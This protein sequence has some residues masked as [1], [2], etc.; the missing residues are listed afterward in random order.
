MCLWIFKTST[1]V[2]VSIS[3][4]IPVDRIGWNAWNWFDALSYM[5]VFVVFVCLSFDVSF[6]NILHIWRRHYCVKGPQYLFGCSALK[7]FE[8]RWIFFVHIHRF[9]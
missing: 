1:F 9:L 3:V 7:S 2:S 6:E 8:Q 5:R 4:M